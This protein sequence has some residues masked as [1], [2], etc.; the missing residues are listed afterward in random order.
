MNQ[1]ILQNI[2]DISVLKELIETLSKNHQ[3][4]YIALMIVIGLN[5]FLE[6]FRLF[7]MYQLSIK[8]KSNKRQLI[9]DEK[10]INVGEDIYRNLDALSSI[11]D[12]KA[13]DDA[14]KKI[15]KYALANR[16]YLSKA[17]FKITNDCL[18]YFINVAA[19]Y[20]RNKDVNKE[21]DF[22][23]KYYDTFNR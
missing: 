20:A 3:S 4:L 19:D 12:P 14:V 5:I 9:L 15:R 23:D 13:I 10:R 2:T 6:G 21:R 11:D 18:D 17:L 8:D 1:I 7:G 22:R 16:L